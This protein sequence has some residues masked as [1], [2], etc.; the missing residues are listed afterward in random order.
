MKALDILREKVNELTTLAGQQNGM[1]KC[2]TLSRIEGIQ[3]AIAILQQEDPSILLDDFKKRKQID[4]INN[5]F[6]NT[7]T[8]PQQICEH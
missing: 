5:A 8:K 2:T 3:L 1:S 6:N 4:F 7:F